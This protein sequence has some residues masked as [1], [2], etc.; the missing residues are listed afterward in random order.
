MTLDPLC[1]NVANAF[2]TSNPMEGG[3]FFMVGLLVPLQLEAFG[4]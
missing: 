4:D 3:S 1:C 2:W